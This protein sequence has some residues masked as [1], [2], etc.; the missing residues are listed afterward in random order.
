VKMRG[1]WIR[2]QA[3]NC[4]L[5]FSNLKTKIRP[6]CHLDIYSYEDNG[7][8]AE[9]TLRPVDI[10][11]N[12]KGIYRISAVIPETKTLEFRIRTEQ[13]SDIAFDY[14]DITYYQGY[15]IDIN[16]KHEIRKPPAGAAVKNSNDQNTKFKTRA[17]DASGPLLKLFKDVL[18]I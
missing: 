1:G 4:K 18:D 3:G 12:K 15:F 9:K 10:K 16:S 14:L 11:K 6:L 2:G 5:K 8:I 13:W 7:P 17:A